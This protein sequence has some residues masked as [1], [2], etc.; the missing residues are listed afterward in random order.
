MQQDANKNETKTKQDANK[1]ANNRARTKHEPGQ[2]TKKIIGQDR[3][4][5]K[6][7]SSDTG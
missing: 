4:C 1:N 7:R 5:I 3:T 6:S 2:I